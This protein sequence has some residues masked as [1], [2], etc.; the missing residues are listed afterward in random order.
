MEKIIIH[1]ELE[2]LRV[3]ADQIY[4]ERYRPAPSATQ[5]QAFKEQLFQHLHYLAPYIPAEDEAAAAAAVN[6]ANTNDLVCRTY[7]FIGDFKMYLE[8][9]ASLRRSFHRLYPRG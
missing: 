1:Q 7:K 3:L 2:A 6:D 9:T 8:S 5:L 4:S